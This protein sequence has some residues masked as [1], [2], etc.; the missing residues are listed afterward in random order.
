MT[1]SKGAKSDEKEKFFGINWDIELSWGKEKIKTGSWL[2]DIIFKKSFNHN[3]F[4]VNF[5]EENLKPE[6]ILTPEAFVY[7]LLEKEP[8][9]MDKVIH[10][11]EKKCGSVV[12]NSLD[13]AMKITIMFKDSPVCKEEGKKIFPVMSPIIYEGDEVAIYGQWE[14]DTFWLKAYQVTNMDIK[15]LLAI[16]DKK[17]RK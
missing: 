10:A 3:L 15:G 14:N 13:E 8:F 4:K 16:C 5:N 11:L 12:I 7:G 17:F 9:R 1:E 2:R 6:Y